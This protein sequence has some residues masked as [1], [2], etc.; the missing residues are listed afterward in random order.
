MLD[1]NEFSRAKWQADG[2]ELD[3]GCSLFLHNGRGLAAY[4]H[5]DV[6]YQAFFI[7]YLVLGSLNVPLNP[8]N[9]YT[10][11]K[12]QNG[13]ATFGPPDIAATLSAVRG[14]GAESRMVSKMVGPFAASSRSGGA[15]VHLTKTHTGGTARPSQQYGA[16]V[17]S[18]ADELHDITAI[19]FRRLFP[20][21]RRPIRPIPPG[22]A[23]SPARASPPSSSSTME[24]SNSEALRACSVQ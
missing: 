16:S 20:R 3:A 9:P 21:A 4:T 11:S 18:R 13:F 24:P 1:P 22:T 23:R 2:K 17:A 12:T 14:R 15:I 7:A 8:G 10:T 5:D 6:L 19:C